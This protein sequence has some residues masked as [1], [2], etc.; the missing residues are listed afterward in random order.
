LFHS[1]TSLSIYESHEVGAEIFSYH[2]HHHRI[3]WLP[4]FFAKLAGNGSGMPQL[5]DISMMPYPGEPWVTIMIPFCRWSAQYSELI[6]MNLSLSVM[7]T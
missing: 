2:L 6:D 5:E 3:T 7:N 4:L 1:T